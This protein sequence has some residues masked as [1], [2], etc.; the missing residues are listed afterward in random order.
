MTIHEIVG[1]YEDHP[2]LFDESIW[3]DL[4]YRFFNMKA[5][6]VPRDVKL[7]EYFVEL[8]EEE[9]Y[10]K[11]INKTFPRLSRYSVFNTLPRNKKLAYWK[12]LDW[13]ELNDYGRRNEL[14][15]YLNENP[16]Y[17]D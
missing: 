13:V 17:Y 14:S 3:Y 9:K 7:D 12:L 15:Q 8:Y 2:R 16:P 5:D 1:L 10:T 6:M 11:L 4:L